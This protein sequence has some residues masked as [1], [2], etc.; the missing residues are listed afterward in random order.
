M[1]ALP[2]KTSN[3][4]T[5]CLQLEKKQTEPKVSKI[6]GIINNIAKISDLDKKTNFKRLT[7]LTWFF[8][9]IKFKNLARQ[10][11]EKGAPKSTKS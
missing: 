1:L 10:I 4:P 11:K 7:K 6:K 2:G 9:K 3:N 5:V 8:K